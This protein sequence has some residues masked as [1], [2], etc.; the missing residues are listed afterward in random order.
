MLWNS[1]VDTTEKPF[2]VG[3]GIGGQFKKATETERKREVQHELE[4]EKV[5][6]GWTEKWWTCLR[7]CWYRN[8]QCRILMRHFSTVSTS[9]ATFLTIT[10]DTWVMIFLLFRIINKVLHQW[11]N[12]NLSKLWICLQVIWGQS[13]CITRYFAIPVGKIYSGTRTPL[14][15]RI[16]NQCR[17]IGYPVRMIQNNL[18][19]QQHIVSSW[20]NGF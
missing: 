12:T 15:V 2:E 7:T 8:H 17:S 3:V 18:I 10:Y 9:S 11:W 14:S 6:K 13:I 5:K 19:I 1:F 4:T 20:T 16:R